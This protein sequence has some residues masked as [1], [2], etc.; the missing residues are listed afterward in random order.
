VTDSLEAAWARTDRIFGFV[1]DHALLAR[2]IPLRQPLLFYVGHLP[3]FAWN[4]MGRGV[5]DLPAFAPDLDALFEAGIDP[6][7]DAEPPRHAD[8]DL[9][10]RLD[11]VLAF[12]DR[13]RSE[14]RSA[15]GEP[16]LAEVQP[17]VLEHELMHQETLMYMLQQLPATAKR[18]PADLAAEPEMRAASPVRE[19]VRVS[20]GKAHLGASPDGFCWDN[21][22][23][24]L[25]V[26]VDAFE[27]DSLPVTN[28]EFRDF[29]SA[30]GYDDPTLW[31]RDGWRWL[32]KTGR[33]M[34]HGWTARARDLGVA[35]VFGDVPF[36]DAAE[37][38]ASV[39]HCEAQAFARWSGA[40]L[41]SEPEFHRAAFATPDGGLRAHPW[42]DAR[43]DPEH[44]N[45]GFHRLRPVSV[46]SHPLGASAFGVHELVGNGWEWTS[47]PFR[48]FPGFA[49]LARYRGYSADFFDER[50]FVLLGGSW[51]TDL[52]LV[53]RSFRNWFQP[54]Y[55]YVFTKFRR[56]YSSR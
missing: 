26:R 19:R 45:L 54:H 36:D 8:A 29:V 11:R 52:R 38:P 27:V 39:S 10:P 53:R 50:H 16:E 25:D 6:R 28:G 35:T 37:W 44:A 49:P 9:W 31:T 12:R 46:G 48:P 20:A 7:D 40:R 2:P 33:A 3:A 32:R 22:R 41:P 13:V 24:E 42:G 18:L 23:P 5:L 21:E 55:P 47:T 43:P 14:L 15:L 17:M 1:A 30:G 34:P 51:A 56:V 4:H